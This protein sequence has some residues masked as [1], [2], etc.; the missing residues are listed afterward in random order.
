M[1]MQLIPLPE[2]CAYI[3][4]LPQNY[5]ERLDFIQVVRSYWN[6]NVWSFLLNLAEI[7][8]CLLFGR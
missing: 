2:Y 8:V 1:F 6:L 7:L 5:S 4:L 3:A